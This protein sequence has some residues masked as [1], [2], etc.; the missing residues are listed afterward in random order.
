[1]VFCTRDYINN[2]LEAM[3]NNGHGYV[4]VQNYKTIGKNE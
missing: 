3:S 1:M 2:S 4:V